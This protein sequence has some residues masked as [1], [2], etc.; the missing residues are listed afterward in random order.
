MQHRTSCL[1]IAPC[2]C[3]STLAQGDPSSR[4]RAQMNFAWL[5]RVSPSADT[6]HFYQLHWYGRFCHKDVCPL[7]N[8]N[9]AYQLIWDTLNSISTET[10]FSSANIQ[11]WFVFF[12]LSIWMLCLFFHPRLQLP[13]AHKRDTQDRHTERRW[14][15][16]NGRD[17][18]E[19]L[20][21][22]LISM[23]ILGLFKEYKN[24]SVIALQ[25]YTHL[26]EDS[27]AYTTA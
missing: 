14:N 22:A 21:Y 16:F 3:A 18:Q 11:S 1:C 5:F 26:V 10:L 9:Y 25:I 7:G 8:P 17:R 24:I 6:T 23:Y 2:Q 4:V 27:R 12:F 15:L 13:R 19:L 20:T